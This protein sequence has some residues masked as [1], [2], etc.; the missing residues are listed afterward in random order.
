ML[1]SSRHRLCPF[2]Y[3]QHSMLPNSRLPQVFFAPVL[4]VTCFVSP[5]PSTDHYVRRFSFPNMLWSMS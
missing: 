5:R 3:F 1:A 4:F 2:D